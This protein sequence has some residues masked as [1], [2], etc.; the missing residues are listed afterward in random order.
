LILKLFLNT[1]KEEQKKRLLDRLENDDKYWKSSAADLRREDL[2]R[3]QS[4]TYEAMLSRTSTKVAP[5]Y[6]I[7]ADYKWAARALIADI[8]AAK[9]NSLELRCPKVKEEQLKDIRAAREQLK[10][11]K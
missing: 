4:K 7:P 10:N 1:S 11:E 5:W 6:T 3:L 9:I 8:V 2:G